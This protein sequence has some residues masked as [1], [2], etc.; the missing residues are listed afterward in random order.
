M[1]SKGWR[2]TEWVILFFAV[3]VYILALGMKETYKKTILAGIAK[4]AGGTGTPGP[5]GI[6]ALKFLFHVTFLRP[7]H[8]LYTEPIVIAWSL[9]IGFSFAVLYSFFAA[10]P[11]VYTTAYGFDIQQIGLTF[12]SLAIGSIAGSATVILIDRLIY[13]K[14][15]AQWRM[16]GSVGRVAPEHRLYS[17]MLGSL[18]LP[19]GLFWYAWTAQPDIHWISSL[20]AAVFISWGNLAIF[21]CYPLSCSM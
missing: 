16:K 15:H 10:F 5:S 18:G 17:A 2:W 13:Q 12:I 14:L 11:Y 6:A 8:M 7:L 4:R 9:Y 3:F 21:V 20:V 19:V 1:A